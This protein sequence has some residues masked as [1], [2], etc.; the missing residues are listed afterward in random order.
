[1]AGK[2]QPQSQSK[3]YKDP[4]NAGQMVGMLVI[5]MFIEENGGITS[6]LIDSIK[7]VCAYNAEIFFEKPSEDIFLMVKNMV[8]E[9]K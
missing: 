9:I 6:D 4:F 5:L 7:K 1:M 2:A 8:K 3:D